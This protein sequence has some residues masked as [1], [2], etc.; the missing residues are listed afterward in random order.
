MPSSS[1]AE[2]EMGSFTAVAVARADMGTAVE[3]LTEGAVCTVSGG[4]RARI[5]TLERQFVVP[6][7]CVPVA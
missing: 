1:Y 7:A 5:A 3:K 4:S 6:H 2:V